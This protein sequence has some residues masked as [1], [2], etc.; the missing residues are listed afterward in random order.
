MP[1]DG[2]EQQAL[3]RIL[4][5]AATDPEFRRRLLTEPK[6]AIRA[7]FG[8]IIPSNFCIKFIERDPAVDALVVLPD[9]KPVD[10]ALSDND[11]EWVSGGVDTSDDFWADTSDDDG[12]I[13]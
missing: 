6:E 1:T 2:G 5:R 7:A 12:N 13:G 9:P 10:G 4:S 8:V 11:L 3:E